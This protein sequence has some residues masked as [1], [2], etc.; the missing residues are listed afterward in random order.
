MTGKGVA[1]MRWLGIVLLLAA[2]ILVS[3]GHITPQGD[4]FQGLNICGSLFLM[5]TSLM[6]P[7]KDWPIALFNLFWVGIGVYNLLAR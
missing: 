1:A 7:K 3:R 5:A 6:L 4:W 2:Y